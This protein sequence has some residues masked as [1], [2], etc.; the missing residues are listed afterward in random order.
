MGNGEWG[1]SVKRSGKLHHSRG[2]LPFPIPRSLA[3]QLY[4][5]ARGARLPANRGIGGDAVVA[6][7]GQ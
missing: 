1:T 5:S 2:M 6:Q 4:A 3:L 7:G